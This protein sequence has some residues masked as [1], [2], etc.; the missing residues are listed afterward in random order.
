VLPARVNAPNIIV[1]ASGGGG[2][3]GGFGQ[4]SFILPLLTTIV[5]DRAS[6]S[7][8]PT[9]TRATTA[10]FIDHEGVLRSVLS[11]EA[12]FSGARRVQNLFTNTEDLTSAAWTKTL[13]TVTAGFTAP[14]G[15]NTAFRLQASP[16]IW[17]IQQ[18]FAMAAN[19]HVNSWWVKSNGAGLDTFQIYVGGAGADSGVITATSE[20]RR[21][22]DTKTT[23]AGSFQNGIT[24]NAIGG[25]LGV[26]I[27]IWR[28]QIENVVGQA[29]DAP[30][31]YVSA[32]V[33]SAPFHGA[34]V[35]G[36]KYFSTTN[37][38]TVNS[39]VVTEATG[40][41][42]STSTLLGYLAEGERT[43]LCLQS[44][45]FTT[46]WVALGTPAA[47]QNVT[48]PDGVANSAWTITDNDAL[49]AEGIVQ[50][51]TL[52]AAAYTMS[53]RIKKTV[54]ATSF[55]VLEA[56][57]GTTT[58]NC[59][60]DTNNG[61]ATIWT[62]YTGRTMLASASATCTSLNTD[63]WLVQMTYTATVAAYTHSIFAAGTTNATQS[64]GIVD[65]TAQGATVLYGAQVELGTFASS[66]I[67][68]TT[69]SVTRNSDRLQYVSTGNV[70]F[71]VGYAYAEVKTIGFTS[72][73]NFGIVGSG[74]S[75]RIIY[76]TGAPTTFRT[77]DG[78]SDVISPVFATLNNSV[79]KLATTWGDSTTR[80]TGR[81]GT[82]TSGSFD[83]SMGSGAVLFVGSYG[84]AD[85]VAHSTIRNL[86][87]GTTQLSAAQLQAM[88]T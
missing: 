56:L 42:I 76:L 7:A 64:T 12:R 67:P 29:S 49:A 5:P 80:N 68:T 61:I 2:G 13:C 36:V 19:K 16:G 84:A 32:G 65:V 21:I 4:P 57:T 44:N 43:N 40:S 87:I 52:T 88:T 6:G 23:T 85:P 54:G 53:A 33:L 70:S 78:T 50:D 71:T 74:S 58:A 22:S 45:A 18:I 59:T 39:N 27:L 15:T 81:A 8:T 30:A 47:T 75:G 86:R 10:T 77:F 73:A 38:N 26:D 24:R 31:E 14:D 9:F 37:G 82:P 35:D 3:Q 34:N 83:G 1:N 72:A 20:W 41:P 66:Y 17:T 60:V 63:Y 28:P 11:G 25:N 55:P 79:G 51:I 48:G 62:A 69:A 46:T